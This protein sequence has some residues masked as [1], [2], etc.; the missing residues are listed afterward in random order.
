MTE[1]YKITINEHFKNHGE[2]PSLAGV[3]MSLDMPNLAFIVGVN[4]SG[5]T[6][7]ANLF[8]PHEDRNKYAVEENGDIWFGSNDR[9]AEDRTTEDKIIVMN[10]N[11]LVPRENTNVS[12]PED[13]NYYEYFNISRNA[14]K[15]LFEE[16]SGEI[17]KDFY[18]DGDK[19]RIE[20]LYKEIL[21]EEGLRFASPMF[22]ICMEFIINN[23]QGMEIENIRR[24]H[25]TKYE[26]KF[27]IQD[28]DIFGNV[29]QQV[30]LK[31][32]EDMRDYFTNRWADIQKSNTEKASNSE[33]AEESINEYGE[34][35]W[36]IIERDLNSSDIF[37]FNIY[38]P[39]GDKV[40][41][42]G[43]FWYNFWSNPLRIYY[44]D[45]P[46]LNLG[47]EKLSSGEKTLFALFMSVYNGEKC[48]RPHMIVLDE[49]DAH[50]HPSMC[51]KM[52]DVLEEFFVK[53]G[54][55]VIVITHHPTT[56]A[57]A[58]EESLFLM[59]KS[60]ANPRIRKIEKQTAVH[61]LSEGLCLLDDAKV[62]FDNMDNNKLNI[63]SE[64]RNYKYIEKA[65]DLLSP[66][67]KNEINLVAGWEDRTGTK[68]L[69]TLA[70]FFKSYDP[71]YKTLF[72]FDCDAKSTHD[73]II[74]TEK[75]KSFCFEKNTENS[76]IEKGI[77]NLFDENNTDVVPDSI[78][79]YHAETGHKNFPNRNKKNLEEHL[80]NNG[81][82][83]MF[84]GFL[85][86]IEKTESII[87]D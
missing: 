86:F 55:K 72:A 16:Y 79:D 25:F 54:V 19:E 31:Y 46:E 7:F 32:A 40:M 6:H 69:K 20:M 59:E 2:S 73:S 44:K 29:V 23:C 80:M 70:G 36:E 42:R 5:K 9:T 82:S 85:P 39:K 53:R 12:L 63:I 67:L 50:L 24:R 64:G 28:S 11:E 15:R 30:C 62:I 66:H 47:L 52:I 1:T 76:I 17:E 41:P 26:P 18:N 35:I 13:N 84:S 77:E 56:V 21:Q 3:T 61:E 75:L 43:D 45:K 51:K 65:I 33:I 27:S 14:Y 49:P 22:F 37:N 10:N 87:N 83:E 60:P 58:P 81:T 68:Q 34:P 57:M 38:F 4:G 71:N 74:E 78:F 8:R 48:Q